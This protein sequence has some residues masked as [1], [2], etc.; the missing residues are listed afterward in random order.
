[1]MEETGRHKDA[2]EYYYTLGEKRSYPQVALKFSVSHTSIRKWGSLFNWQEKIV[3][4]DTE[5]ARGVE[6]KVT[7]SNIDARAKALRDIQNLKGILWTTI[8]TAFPKDKKTGKR[9]PNIKVD[10]SRDISSLTNSLL[11]AEEVAL[12]IAGEPEKFEHSGTIKT[13]NIKE[14]VTKYKDALN[15]VGEG[16]DS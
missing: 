10:S 16:T 2:F 7:K 3:I 12:K 14:V 1:M 15:E 6:A 4:R 11:R 8:E 5:I 9:V 13:V